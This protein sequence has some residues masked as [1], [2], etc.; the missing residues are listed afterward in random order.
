MALAG[1]VKTSAQANALCKRMRYFAARDGQL[2]RR[3]K[4]DCSEDFAW[5]KIL[6]ESGPCFPL[7][8]RASARCVVRDAMPMMTRI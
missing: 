8:L 2:F 3:Q 6:K 5:R 1:V 4:G 7:R